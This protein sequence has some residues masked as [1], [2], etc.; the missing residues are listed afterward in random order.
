MVRYSMKLHVNC[1]L[2]YVATMILKIQTTLLIVDYSTLTYFPLQTKSSC[3]CNF[4][5]SNIHFY[6]FHI[7]FHFIIVILSIPSLVTLPYLPLPLPSILGL[8][9]KKKVRPFGGGHMANY[10]WLSSAFVN[11]TLLSPSIVILIH[12]K[13]QTVFTAIFL[14]LILEFFISIVEVGINYLNLNVC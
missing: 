6:L 5:I 12:H 10:A 13:V 1:S 11:A 4:L 9:W 7:Q 8:S 14:F 3:P 2:N